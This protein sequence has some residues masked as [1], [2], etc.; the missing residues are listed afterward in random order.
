M[1]APEVTDK[2]VAAIGSGKFDLVVV[3]FAN[4]DMVGH[5]GNIKAAIKAV[6]AVDACLARLRDAVVAAGGGLL[7]TGDPGN[8]E[9]MADA[10]SGAHHPLLTP[11]RAGA[12][13]LR[14]REEGSSYGQYRW[15]A[16]Q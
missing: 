12:E 4:T 8:A 6:E 14:V 5:S 3:N 15:G 11:Y 9:L 7:D 10:A 2:L 1:S 13:A 16:D